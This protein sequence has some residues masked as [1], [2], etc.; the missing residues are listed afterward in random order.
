MPVKQKSVKSKAEYYCLWVRRDYEPVWR[1]VSKHDTREGAQ[2]ELER[3]RGFTGVFNYDNAE[4]RVLSRAE[5]RKEFGKDWDYKPIGSSRKPVMAR[6]VEQ[7][8][9]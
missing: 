7:D 4:L 3:R 6:E 9:E 1:A 8:E 2:A 5:A